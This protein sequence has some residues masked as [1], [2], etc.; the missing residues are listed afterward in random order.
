MDPGVLIVGAMPTRRQQKAAR[1]VKE[2]VSD[3][4]THHLGDPRIQGLVSVT[5]VAVAADLRSAD[6][7]VS[8][9]GENEAAQKRTYAA[10]T[11]ARSKI[12][13]LLADRWRMKFCPVLRLYRDEKFKQMLETMRLI[14][15]AA[16]EFEE[17][18]ASD[19]EQ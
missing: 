9:L 6:V 13:A 7:Y 4:I 11:H 1:V 17:K 10:I 18:D 5:R 8:I 16:S 12:Q 14:D 2:T 15:Q 3:A 19:A